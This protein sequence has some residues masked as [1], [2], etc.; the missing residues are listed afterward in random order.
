MYHIKMLNKKK[1]TII[2]KDAEKK[3]HGVIQLPYLIKRKRNFQQT[4]NSKDF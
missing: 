4:N 1:H 3:K 2:L